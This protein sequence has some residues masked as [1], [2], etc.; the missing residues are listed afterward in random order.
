M[1][2]LIKKQESPTEPTKNEEEIHLEQMKIKVKTAALEW[3]D[4]LLQE[5]LKSLIYVDRSLRGDSRKD[6]LIDELNF[7]KCM[8]QQSSSFLVLYTKKE[9]L[10][11]IRNIF[12]PIISS[13]I[14]LFRISNINQTW[15]RN[16]QEK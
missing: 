12:I 16:Y 6:K 13:H 8:R 3:D 7:K 11:F 4:F 15:F 2:I 14:H 9:I 5:N 10:L 1:D